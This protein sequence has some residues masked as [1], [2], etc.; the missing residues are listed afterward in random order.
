MPCIAVPNKRITLVINNPIITQPVGEVQEYLHVQVSS[1]SCI[2]V[3]SV[4]VLPR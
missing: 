3:G 1:I 4:L 2:V